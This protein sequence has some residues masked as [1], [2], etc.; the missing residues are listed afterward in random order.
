[1]MP[2]LTTAEI[3]AYFTGL[4]GLVTAI[5]TWYRNRRSSQID[6]R[7]QLSNEQVAFRQAMAAELAALRTEIT[8]LRVAN[9]KL[10]AQQLESVRVQE[11]QSIKLEIAEERIKAQ[12]D[13]IEALERENATLQVAV[14]QGTDE[15]AKLAHAAQMAASTKEFLER[16]NASIRTENERLRGLLPPRID[17]VA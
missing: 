3:V 2:Q 15:R 14:A 12:R 9:D 13:R 4:A 5:A 6:D 7:T 1:M 11:R 16:E 8:N 17:E 10:E